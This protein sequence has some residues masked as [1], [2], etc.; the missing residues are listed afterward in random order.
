MHPTSLTRSRRVLRF[1]GLWL[2]AVL[3]WAAVAQ[4]PAQP[5]RTVLPI[6][7]PRRPVYTEIDARNVKPPEG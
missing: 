3:P 4:A 2:A 6:P 5:D 7:E 1:A